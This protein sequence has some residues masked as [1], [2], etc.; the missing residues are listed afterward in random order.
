MRLTSV[1]L[2]ALC[3]I[4]LGCG[5]NN[6]PQPTPSDLNAA[7]G[8]PSSSD[9]PLGAS[10]VTYLDDKSKSA[11]EVIAFGDWGTENEPMITAMSTF[12]A[13]FAHPDAVFLLGDNYYSDYQASSFKLFTQYVA[14]PGTTRAH[15]VILGNHDHIHGLKKQLAYNKQDQRWILPSKYYFNRFK[16]VGFDVCVWFLDTEGIMKGDSDQ[17]SWLESSMNQNGPSCKWKIVNGHHPLMHAS[18]I[19]GQCPKP[20]IPIRLILAKNRIHLYLSGH[21]HNSQ[22]MQHVQSGVYYAIAGGIMQLRGRPNPTKFPVPGRRFLW[23]SGTTTALL[24]LLIDGNSIKVE[25]HSGENPQLPI[26]YSYTIA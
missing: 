6:T 14:P 10:F 20:L 18:P 11:M 26:L 9:T 25:F 17:I 21:H 23:G 3:G 16:L 24:R 1:L 13:K 19:P 22:F 8:I 7:A 12:N 4:L 2:L 15:Y 5:D